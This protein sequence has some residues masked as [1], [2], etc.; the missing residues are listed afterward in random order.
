[1]KALDAMTGWRIVDGTLEF[2]DG[3]MVIATFSVK[4]Q[5]LS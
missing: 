2:L 3:E 1:M 5:R 4:P